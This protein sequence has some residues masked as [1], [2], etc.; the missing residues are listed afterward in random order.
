M[1]TF[2]KLCVQFVERADY[3]GL[4]GKARETE[5]LAF[6][7]GASSAL[8]TIDH[9]DKGHVL[10]CTAMIIASRGYGEVKRIADEAL[11]EHANAA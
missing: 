10:G 2:Q 3:M 6:F 8:Q 1:N 7:V 4:K 9:P 11:R 5:C